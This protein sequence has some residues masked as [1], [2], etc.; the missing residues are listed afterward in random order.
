[1]EI[2]ILDGDDRRIT[3]LLERASPSY[4]N[5]LRRTMLSEVPTLAIEEV[6]IYENTSSLYDEILAHRLGLVPIRT[7]LKRF[8]FRDE[9]VCGGKGCAS[10]TLTLTLE[11]EG[12]KVVYSH[13][14]RSPDPE[15][16]PVGGIPLVK[17]GKGQRLRLEAEAVLGR[18][19]EHAKWQPCVVGYKYYPVITIDADK[20]TACGECVEACPRDLLALEDRKVMVRDI[21][22]CSLCR[23]C[24]QTCE[25]EALTVKGD[26]ERFIFTIESNGSLPAKEIFREACREISK[27]AGK[28]VSL[29]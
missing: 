19:K 20:C 2:R 17:L 8:N 29:L 9:C 15:L 26:P 11:E 22:N 18:G 25:E 23:A 13:D 27:K 4:A 1:M 5:A 14:L 21:E 10:C 6:I 7:D 12:P 16:I 3:L 28:M 24:S